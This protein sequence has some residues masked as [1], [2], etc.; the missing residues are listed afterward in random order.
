MK[1]YEFDGI[2][3]FSTIYWNIAFLKEECNKRRCVGFKS[4]AFKVQKKSDVSNM[5]LQ[6]ENKTEF[7]PGYPES[8]SFSYYNFK[9][10]LILA[11]Y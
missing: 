7:D 6:T 5:P 4:G 11:Q 3:K 1:L 10:K 8:R 2:L 9:V